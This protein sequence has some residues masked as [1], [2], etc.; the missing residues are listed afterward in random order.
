MALAP[1]PAAVPKKAV[2]AKPVAKPAIANPMAQSLPPGVNPAIARQQMANANMA[3]QADILSDQ[4]GRPSMAGDYS[5]TM[6]NVPAS[7]QT[8]AG[9]K[10]PLPNP[11]P[12]PA[13][14]KV[15]R[16]MGGISPFAGRG[17]GGYQG[18]GNFGGNQSFGNRSGSNPFMQGLNRGGSR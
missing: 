15:A 2:V 12:L 18:Y 10:A 16:P 17:A 5:N 8:L 4:Q 3:R 6:K 1:K 11:I 14:T 7:V 9:S 13:P